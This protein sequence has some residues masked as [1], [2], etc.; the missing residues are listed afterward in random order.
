MS[1]FGQVT[2]QVKELYGR[3][4]FSQKLASALLILVVVGALV[5]FTNW[6][7]RG[8]YVRVTREPLGAAEAEVVSAF[9]AAGI[10]YRETSGML[11]V[12]SGQYNAAMAILATH[13]IVPGEEISIR[14]A[15]VAKDDKM[16]RTAEDKRAQR[17]VALQNW[18][19]DVIS[20]ME[21]IRAASVGIDAPDGTLLMGTEEKG[22]AAVQ[23]WLAQGVDRLSSDQVNGIAA[24]VAGVRRTIQKPDVRIVDNHGHE[25]RVAGDEESAGMVS[26]RQQEQMTYERRLA[27]EVREMLSYYDPIKVLVRLKID[28]DRKTEDVTD[29]NPERAVEV[30]TRRETSETTPANAGLRLAGVE[31]AVDTKDS[32]YAKREVYKK[33]THLV[34]APGDVLDVS[35]SVFVPREQVIEQ[36]KGRGIAVDEKAADAP[37]AEEVDRVKKSIVNML[38]VEDESK[39]TVQAVTF[40]KPKLAEGPAEPGALGALWEKCGHATVLAGLCLIALVLLWRLVKKPVEVA[41]GRAGGAGDEEILVGIEGAEASRTRAERVES[42]VKDLV[43]HNPSDAAGLLSRWI[44]SEG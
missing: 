22:T 37:I 35:V 23:V 3:L 31:P 16:F 15:D 38:L 27:R 29:V 41:G 18:L 44:Q 33:V 36:A 20:H 25:Y 12:A 8:E 6:G 13:G 9:G 14:L 30:E 10:E 32:R 19:A 28:F 40:P 1:F 26:D 34:K 17:M 4:T 11:E 21:N 2:S 43:K 7:G 39:I 42:Q 5:L 24:L